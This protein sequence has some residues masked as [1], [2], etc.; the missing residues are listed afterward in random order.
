MAHLTI[1]QPDGAGSFPQDTSAAGL[2]VDTEI[3][4]A[5][6]ESASYKHF[7]LD[8][9]DGS[10]L[11]FSADTPFSTAQIATLT[12]DVIGSYRGLSVAVDGN[13]VQTTFPWILRVQCDSAG[14]LVADGIVAPS[15]GEV[16]SEAPET[17]GRGAATLM[18]RAIARLRGLSSVAWSEAPIVM[19]GQTITTYTG[20][21]AAVLTHAATGHQDGAEKV[22]KFPAGSVTSLR[23]SPAINLRGDCAVDDATYLVSDWNAAI[24]HML[25]LERV[26]GATFG[27]LR[28]AAATDAVAPTVVSA[29]VDTLDANKLVVVFSE[30]VKVRD[31]T[32]MSLNFTVGTARTITAIESGEGTATVAFTLSGNVSS[33]DSLS[34]VVGSG[35]LA[36]DYYGNALALGSTP[37]TIA[38]G[39]LARAAW[40]RCFEKGVDMLPASGLPAALTSWTDQVSG[41]LQIQQTAGGGSASRTT[42]GLSF[43]ADATERCKA[44]AA[45]TT[46]SDFALYARVKLNSGGVHDW[47]PVS[48]DKDG[49]GTAWA[50]IRIISDG[51]NMTFTASVYSG[52]GSPHE[53]SYGIAADTAEHDLFL[54]HSGGNL[55]FQVDAAAVTPEADSTSL[56][57]LT[58]LGVG[59]A[60]VPGAYK[61]DAGTV[62]HV[63]S[64]SNAGFVGT[65][66]TDVRTYAA[67]V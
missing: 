11:S 54:W 34:F 51:T 8:R 4:I 30:P 31:L 49:A 59:S 16:P 57:G 46:G 47:V 20:A 15:R 67:A 65:E 9:V 10:S 3:E 33:G 66:I 21:T 12:P 2:W 29:T 38:A 64:K 48:W 28:A 43:T 42:G 35:R 58:T 27:T 24:D 6:T 14:G 18:D 39:L 40:T 53:M 45:L 55:H 44:T 26:G 17:D 19:T 32:G 37:V 50:F 7:L 60:L 5:L 62:V 1:S 22:I 23:V 61:P 13:G 56:T 52:T 36:T 41:S 25:I 63:A